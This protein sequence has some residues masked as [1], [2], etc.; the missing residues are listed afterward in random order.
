MLF[1]TFMWYVLIIVAFLFLLSGIDEIFMDIFFWIRFLF[2]TWKMKKYKKITYEDLAS[3]PEQKIAIMVA[4]WHEYE[5][6][7]EMLRYNVT[8]VDYENYKIFVGVYP[9]D[10]ETIQAVA[11]SQNKYHQVKMVIGKVPGP[12]T[13]AHN[14]NQIYEYIKDYEEEHKSSFDIIVI[15]DSED[16]I[17][18][19]SLKLYNYLIPRKDMLQLPVFPLE[20][21]L[22]RVTHW[23][24]NDEF[25]ENHTKNIIVREAI[26]GLVP[27]AG[28]STAFSRRALAK[29]AES[30]DKKPFSTSIF[31]EDYD[32]ALRIN[33]A[34]YK[35]IFVFQKIKV[36]RRIKTIFGRTKEVVTDE[37]IASRS[38][39]PMSYRK[40]VR[41]KSRWILGIT[42]QEWANVGWLGS[43][44]TR[45]TLVQDRKA[46]LTHLISLIGYIVFFFW[47]FY[48]IWQSVN[49]NYPTLGQY[50]AAY[51]W[52]WVLIILCGILM[53]ERLTQRAIAVY[54]IYG[55]FPAL[56]SFPR[57]IYG[58]IINAHAL[59]R[60]YRTFLFSTRKKG[61][62]KWEKTEHA[63]PSRSMFEKVERKLGVLLLEKNIITEKQLIS[64]LSKHM[65][66]GGLLGNI[67]VE[68]E[69]IT[70]KQLVEALGDQFGLK[71]INKGDF[72]PLPHSS[73]PEISEKNYK[74]LLKRNCFP[75]K[76]E[77][78]VVIVAIPYAHITDEAFKLNVVKHIKPCDIRFMLYLDDIET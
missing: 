41:Q 3:K 65:Q 29:L 58:N 40:S 19:L 59:L 68:E 57:A 8:G 30:N 76:R 20:V 2:R 28:V 26:G 55:F 54:R 15:H 63:F 12:T 66:K 53:V 48:S 13:K 7:A 39:F 35:S 25:A 14:L 50:F 49:P 1:I 60:A 31:T 52:V 64:S 34:G 47:V 17:H 22:S 9:N 5:V 11:S 61:G 62:I 6:I 78:Q 46:L 51:P 42:L 10:P 67:M 43:L 75:I 37:V 24:Y 69:I 77:D 32:V 23:I 74:R 73:L 71:V 38:L 27:S 44:P 36:T 33:L 70:E 18:P 4:C 21:P 16:M 72:E 45:Y 56:L